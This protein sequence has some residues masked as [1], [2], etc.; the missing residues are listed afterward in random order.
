MS[1]MTHI[2]FVDWIFKIISVTEEPVDLERCFCV[3]HNVVLPRQ[4]AALAWLFVPNLAGQ[5][6]PAPCCPVFLVSISVCKLGYLGSLRKQKL[7]GPAC[8]VASV[9]WGRA[10]LCSVPQVP[11]AVLGVPGGK[12]CTLKA[13]SAPWTC[14]YVTVSNCDTG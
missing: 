10:V 11:S 7:G 5:L 1:D 3:R 4:K 13:G 12:A 8:T 6:L 2:I 14:I 9:S